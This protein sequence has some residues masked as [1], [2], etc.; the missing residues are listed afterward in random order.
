MN[1]D[2]LH[3]LKKPMV[4]LGLFLVSSSLFIYEVLTTRLFSTVLIYHFVF[5]VTSLAILG[6]G[7]GGIIVFF[8]GNKLSVFKDR[9]RAIPLFSLILSLSYVIIT[10][11]IYNLP[12]M[13]SFII[14]S[15]MAS[16]PFI[17]GGI[18]LSLIFKE[19]NNI[20]HKL[21]FADLLGASIGS[22]GILLLMDG[23][24]FLGSLIIVSIMA[25]IGTIMFNIK[26]NSRKLR[27]ISI[28]LLIFFVIISFYRPF[29]KNLEK[30]FTA[31]ITSPNTVISYWNNK[32][33]N[34]VDIEYTKWDSISRTDVIDIGNPNRKTIITDGNA[35]APMVKF[36]GDLE[37]VEYLKENISYIP[38][39]IGNNDSSL[40][41]GSGG[42]E[43]VL[44]ALLGESKEIDAVE[45]N[46]STIDAVNK[47]KDFNGDIYNID[48]V[49]LY[50]QDGRK[51]INVTD[52]KYDHIYLGKVFSGVVDNS[53]A[54][55]SENYIYTEEAYN[56]Y[57]DH[58]RENG[59]LTFVFND[60]RELFKSLNTMTKVLVERGVDKN[61]ITKHFIAVNSYSKE[62]S[63]KYNDR[64]YMPIVI[65]K[66]KPFTQEE[67]NLT[68]KSIESQNREIINLPYVE[69]RKEI[70][71]YEQYGNGNIT[72]E[73]LQ[74][75]FKFNAKPTTDNKPFFYD[76]D[77]GIPNTLLY[78]L[79]GVL[80]LAIVLF[81]SIIGNKNLRK[82]SI[83]F[84]VIGLGF[85]LVEIPFIQKTI[86]FMGSTTRAFSFILFAL[87]FS[88]GIGSYISSSNIIEKINEKRDYIFLIIGVVNVVLA[89]ISP[90]V[91]NSFVG[92][93]VIGKFFIVF[94][95]IFPLG[96][97]L[98]MP[99]PRGI[100]KI[101]SGTISNGI[102]L[103]WGINGIMSVVSSIL[104]LIISMKLGFNTALILG[105]LF[106]LLLFVKN[107][108]RA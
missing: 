85:M 66:E 78:L 99:F 36:D 104:S 41:I 59:R 92:I 6:S 98:G 107:P 28:I 43:D 35:S 50:I 97:F 63:E 93:N 89:I 67:V 26:G 5:L 75:V 84:S 42:G 101:S 7:I 68:L 79:L 62:V 51:F 20:G 48:G 71:L 56:Q 10:L 3:T 55:M 87:L 12:Y 47:Y 82:V 19:F 4:M 14:Y 90:V 38:F 100:K 106:Y 17:F 16:I 46:P 11:L 80:T 83:Y 86:L 37:E 60:V 39:T 45:I 95:L 61:D 58:L 44:L 102:P 69:S 1:K 72:F 53:A 96:L 21:Y 52:N 23:L 108:L 64:I 91:F 70:S 65:Y 31:Y 25:M 33:E 34:D 8:F 57:L 49:S 2:S 81:L 77:K 22:L 73:K 54:M 103:A 105:T 24:G 74:D 94:L 76:Y 18:I 13:N 30:N 88:G 9:H 40:L 15:L 29:I 27:L 32:L